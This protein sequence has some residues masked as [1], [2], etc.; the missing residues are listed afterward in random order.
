M[1]FVSYVVAPKKSLSTGTAITNTAL[2]TFDSNPAIAT[3]Q[4]DE[5][6]PTKGTDPTK[7]ALITIDSGAPDSKVTAI[8]PLSSPSFTVNWSGSDDTGGSGIAHFAVFV[9]D[10]H[11]A[12]TLWQT[13]PGTQTSA[14][15]PGQRGHSYA[16]YSV[17]TDNVGNL[18]PT[19]ASAQATTTVPTQVAT[20]TTLTSDHPL[21]STYG[22]D[23]TITATVASADSTTGAP[24]GTV[25]FLLDGVNFGNPVTLSGGKASILIPAVNL[26]AG[27]RQ[28]TATYTSDV[29]LFLG[30][31]TPISFA[32]SVG[33]AQLTITPTAVSKVY[34]AALPAFSV[35]FSGLVNGDTGAGFVTSIASTA[36][37][38]SNVGTYP[39]TVT[40][41]GN[42]NY[43]I[44]FN[45][46]T[47]T[48]TPAPLTITADNQTMVAG[49]A[50]PPLTFTFSGLVNGDTAANLETPPVG[51]VSADASSPAGTYPI[52]VSGAASHNYTITFVPGTLTITPSSTSGIG[53]TSLAVA[54]PKTITARG[55]VVPLTGHHIAVSE[56]TPGAILTVTVSTSL[57]KLQLHIGG[58][59]I[60]G[61][62]SRRL[63]LIGN[64]V[65]IN[66]AL[67]A[68]S[69]VLTKTHAKAKISFSATD[70]HNHSQGTISIK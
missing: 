20:S 5:N 42:S 1:G 60:K 41:P 4:V 16:F 25:Q 58:V 18:Q 64:Q 8:A 2:V 62:N 6:D 33:P 29:Q 21:G 32:Q 54:V 27:A 13:F 51:S 45:P 24:T 19:P 35:Q 15:Y 3:D 69:L 66:K 31:T 50:V 63:I 68:I 37:A 17:A 59:K 57:G 65:A 23:V 67:N 7:Q 48:V 30:N 40:G 14:T 10:N 70:G 22:Q 55:F 46:G 44:S 43:I 26:K 36:T 49:S 39:I 9:S 47:L 38:A 34:G 53:G 28:I 52:T 56:P 12:A 11:G 61:N